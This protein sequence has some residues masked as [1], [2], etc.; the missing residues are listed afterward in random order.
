VSSTVPIATA[1][2]AR[3]AN[4]TPRAGKTPATIRWNIGTSALPPISAI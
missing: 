2:S 1:T 4:V 3:G